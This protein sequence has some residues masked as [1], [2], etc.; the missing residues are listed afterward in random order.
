MANRRQLGRS[1]APKS[2]RPRKPARS[3]VWLTRAVFPRSH[4]APLLELAARVVDVRP[5][6]TPRETVAR[7]L[8]SG[9]VE[10][11][12]RFGLDKVLVDLGVDLDDPF[13]LADHEKFLPAL[14]GTVAL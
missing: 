13:A 5:A 11:C 12:M 1:V 14:A 3:N 4:L 10:V 7:D 9:F 6:S 8:L 2:T